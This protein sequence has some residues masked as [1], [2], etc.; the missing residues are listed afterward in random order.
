[1][2]KPLGAPSSAESINS[3]ID[4]HWGIGV[5]GRTTFLPPLSQPCT[6]AIIWLRLSGPL[7]WVHMPPISR[8]HGGHHSLPYYTLPGALATTGC[9]VTSYG[10]PSRTNARRGDRTPD[11]LGVNEVLYLWAIRAVGHQPQCITRPTYKLQCG[12]PHHQGCRRSHSERSA[13][14]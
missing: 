13:P 10:S 11:N 9:S 4:N 14:T 3:F 12:W 2:F 1:M 6:N 5:D 7:V 8:S